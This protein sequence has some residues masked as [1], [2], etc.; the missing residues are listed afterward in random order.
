MFKAKFSFVI[1]AILIGCAGTQEFRNA[2]SIVATHKL[3][4]GQT[5]VSEW[6]EHMESEGF[7]CEMIENGSFSTTYRKKQR[8]DDADFLRCKR[9]T[10]DGIDDVALVVED[11]AVIDAIIDFE[12][13]K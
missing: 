4:N 13:N 9:K 12:R 1:V 3:F 5:T 11:G 2:E 6:Q 8:I 10:K 7:E